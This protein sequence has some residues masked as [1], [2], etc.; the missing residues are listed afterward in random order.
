MIEKTLRILWHLACFG[1]ATYGAL[2][3]TE[4]GVSQADAA[5]VMG[6][7]WATGLFVAISHSESP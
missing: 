2:Q 5:F 7:L 6:L 1:L 3:L 4:A